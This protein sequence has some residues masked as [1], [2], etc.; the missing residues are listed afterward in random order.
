MGMS[1]TYGY[2]A[3]ECRD[4]KCS[5]APD[6]C[7]RYRGRSCV[8]GECTHAKQNLFCA[9]NYP[10]PTAPAPVTPAEPDHGG[11]AYLK[12]DLDGRPLLGG[13][14]AD[15]ALAARVGGGVLLPFTYR[16]PIDVDAPD[17]PRPLRQAR[18]VLE[19]LGPVVPDSER[20][21]KCR[22]PFDPTDD[23]FDGNGQ[24]GTK[25]WCRRCVDRCHESTDFAHRCKVCE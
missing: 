8:S 22:T 15:L 21:A 19:D 13:S 2:L 5:H 9:V 4:Q 18:L 7:P 16:D 25:P 12:V 23:R 14:L 24:Y 17:A 3:P 20:C 6:R 1:T 11:R 10:E